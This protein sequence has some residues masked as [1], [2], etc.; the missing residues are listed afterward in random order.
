MNARCCRKGG[1]GTS[2]NYARRGAQLS[3]LPL[4]ECE[5]K[6]VLNQYEVI[7]P[8]QAGKTALPCCQFVAWWR[9]VGVTARAHVFQG[10]WNHGSL[11]EAGTVFCVRGRPVYRL[12][13]SIFLH[14]L[15]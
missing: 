7:H 13:C 11:M 8:R 9:F 14:S 6:E 5:A 15:F 12:Q 2:K 1:E 10:V 4:A 3:F